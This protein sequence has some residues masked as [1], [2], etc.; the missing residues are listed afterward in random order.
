MKDFNHYKAGF[1]M[2]LFLLMDR[3]LLDMDLLNIIGCGALGILFLLAE[4]LDDKR[5]KE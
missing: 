1:F 4:K 5:N 3:Y 2:L